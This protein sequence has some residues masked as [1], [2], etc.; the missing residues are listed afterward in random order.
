MVA[1]SKN[2]E[3]KILNAT[4]RK[5]KIIMFGSVKNGSR[6]HKKIRSSSRMTKFKKACLISDINIM[7]CKRKRTKMPYNCLNKQGPA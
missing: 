5:R 6:Y 2:G 7:L 1:F 3:L 4:W